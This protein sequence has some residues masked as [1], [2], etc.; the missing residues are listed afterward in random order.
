VGEER[1]GERRRVAEA[2][3]EEEPPGRGGGGHGRSAGRRR[4]WN[5]IAR[6]CFCDRSVGR[7]SHLGAWAWPVGLGRT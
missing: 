7:A 1:D 5:A 6:V 2:Q 3:A 4:G